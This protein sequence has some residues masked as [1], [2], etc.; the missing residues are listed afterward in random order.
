M[1][2]LLINKQQQEAIRRYTMLQCKVI[3]VLTVSIGMA[4][5]VWWLG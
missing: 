4:M 2:N 5:L 3:G 1:Q